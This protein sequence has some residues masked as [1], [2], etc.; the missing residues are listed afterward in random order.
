MTQQP[1]F[2]DWL[3]ALKNASTFD[4]YRLS[5]LIDDELANPQRLIRVLASI[6]PGQ[7]AAYY[8]ASTRQQRPCR[9]E[10]TLH[11]Y[12]VVLDLT[13]HKRYKIPPYMLNLD[14]QSVDISLPQ[15]EKLE[16]HHVSVG[17][18]VGFVSAK[19]GYV[20]GEVIRLN[21][22]TVTLRTDDDTEWRVGYGLLRRPEIQR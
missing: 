1:T 6:H 3:S 7:E 2:T 21:Q 17:A 9:I 18:R 4:L 5:A 12:V 20:E 15:G 11:K 8:H 22:K 19:A 10:R 14:G 16:R 13:D